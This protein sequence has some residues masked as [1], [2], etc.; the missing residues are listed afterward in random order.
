MRVLQ[1]KLKE[2]KEAVAEAQLELEAA[3]IAASQVGFG[4]LQIRVWATG[5]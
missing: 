1:K 3:R 5:A 2:A 4:P